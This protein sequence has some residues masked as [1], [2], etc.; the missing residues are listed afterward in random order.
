MRPHKAFT[1]SLLLLSL[2]L[3][4]A[5]ARATVLLPADLGELTRRAVTIARGRVVAVDAQW[6]EGRR[7]IETVVTLDAERSLKGPSGSTIQFRVPG[8]RLGRFRN[9]VVG[10]P[11]FD[12]GQRVI[13]FLGPAGPG[14]PYTVGLA[15]GVFRIAA[16][17]A[18]AVVISPGV[19]PTGATLRVVRGDSAR[20]PM[21]LSQFEDEIR[22]LAGTSR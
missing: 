7:R 16:G 12:L 22:R 19:L 17:E 21:P 11:R 3:L 5:S 20:R 9:I 13:V 4:V 8:G 15:Q 14:L 2:A 1:V 6:V 10:A 18:D